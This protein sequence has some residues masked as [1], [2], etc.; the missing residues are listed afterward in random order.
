MRWKMKFDLFIFMNHEYI[1]TRR[2]KEK[3]HWNIERQ[4]YM[5]SMKLYSQIEQILLYYTYIKY[6]WKKIQAK[7]F[8][9]ATQNKE[10]KNCDLKEMLEIQYI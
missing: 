7:R 2:I 4:K 3:T 6:L 8:P 10:R 9:L 1:E 5:I